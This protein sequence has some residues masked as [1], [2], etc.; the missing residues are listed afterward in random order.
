MPPSPA[1]TAATSFPSSGT[2]RGRSPPPALLGFCV[3]QPLPQHQAVPSPFTAHAV[4]YAAG[5]G[6]GVIDAGASIAENAP[7]L[8]PSGFTALLLS[9]QQNTLP[10]ARSAHPK[11]KSRGTE[12]AQ[13][14]TARSAD[15]RHELVRVHAVAEHAPLVLER[16]QVD[17]RERDVDDVLAEERRHVDRRGVV[18]RL[19]PDSMSPAGSVSLPQQRATPF[20]ATAHARWPPTAIARTRAVGTGIRHVPPPVP[21]APPPAPAVE[22]PVPAPPPPAPAAAAARARRCAARTRCGAPVPAAPP[23]FRGAS[24]RARGA[25]ARASSAAA[26]RAAGTWPAGACRAAARA[27]GGDERRRDAG[28]R[29]G[30]QDVA[31]QSTAAAHGVGPHCDRRKNRRSSPATV[32]SPTGT[33]SSTAWSRAPTKPPK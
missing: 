5:D 33:H 19:S 26:G 30:G 27:T 10:S 23:P 24:A 13:I 16:A 1:F 15:A 11:P 17:A 6:D 12:P 29:H 14:W 32:V 3:P 22:P 18:E 28:E 4:A 21:A 20:V 9:P 25:S 7:K 8:S 2:R 31:A